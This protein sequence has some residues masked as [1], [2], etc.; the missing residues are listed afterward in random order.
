MAV[1]QPSLEQ[2]QTRE[3]HRRQ[4]LGE[5]RGPSPLFFPR[6]SLT[7][8]LRRCSPLAPPSRHQLSSSVTVVSVVFPR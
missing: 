7:C 6:P 8:R 1:W 2:H 5:V 3:A 4:F